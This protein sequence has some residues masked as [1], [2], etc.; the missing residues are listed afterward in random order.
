MSDVSTEIRE[1]E[2]RL[3]DVEAADI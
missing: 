1:E 2:P 3:H